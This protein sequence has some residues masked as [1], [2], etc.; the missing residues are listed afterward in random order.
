M[1]FV[2]KDLRPHVGEG[3]V[4]VGVGRR[5]RGETVAEYPL[6]NFTKEEGKKKERKNFPQKNSSGCVENRRG[7]TI[8]RNAIHMHT[9]S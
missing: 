6:N 8:R 7:K 5:R 3:A 2:L 9:R 4:G 1:S